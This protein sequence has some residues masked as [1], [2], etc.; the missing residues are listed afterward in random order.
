MY[1]NEIM[2]LSAIVD[3]WLIETW[4]VLKS[5]SGN[6]AVPT[7]ET[8]N[9]N[10]RCI[11]ILRSIRFVVSG[12]WLIETWDVLKFCLAFVEEINDYW[13]I[14][15]W[16]VLKC[17]RRAWQ[18]SFTTRLI[19]T[20]DVLKSGLVLFAEYLDG[21]NRNMRCIEILNKGQDVQSKIGLIETWDVLKWT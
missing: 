1:W 12:F 2:L 14:E 16:D 11:E 13:L 15:T 18:R 17:F 9:R 8:I 7:G 5:F 3:R 6:V 4:D 20:W 21:I 10:M 19:E